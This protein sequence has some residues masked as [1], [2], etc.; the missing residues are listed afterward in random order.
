MNFASTFIKTFSEII[1]LPLVYS[2]RAI[3]ISNFEPKMYWTKRETDWTK[4]RQS[5]MALRS[6]T[7]GIC[8][9]AISPAGRF[10]RIA[11]RGISGA[12]LRRGSEALIAAMSKLGQPALWWSGRTSTRGRGS[13][14]QEAAT[15]RFHLKPTQQH[16]LASLTNGDSAELTRGHYQELAGVSRSQA[17]YDLAELVEAC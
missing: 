16:A 12:Y 2:I 8:K 15:G 5:L 4:A 6:D 7:W 1:A 14:P 3:Y 11:R 13:V 9:A 10:F 17:A